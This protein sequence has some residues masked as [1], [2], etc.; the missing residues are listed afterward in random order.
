MELKETCGNINV[1]HQTSKR[2]QGKEKQ[3][4]RQNV[5]NANFIKCQGGSYIQL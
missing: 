5:F 3:L 2:Q 1:H 4:E